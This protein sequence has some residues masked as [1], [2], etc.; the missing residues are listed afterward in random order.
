MDGALCC[1]NMIWKRDGGE[2]HHG[3]HRSRFRAWNSVS[4][5]DKSGHC[6]VLQKEILQVKNPRGFSLSPGSPCGRWS[7]DDKPAD[8]LLARSWW[9]M[10]ITWKFPSLGEPRAHPRLLPT[11]QV[12]PRGQADEGSPGHVPLATAGVKDSLSFSGW[13]SRGSAKE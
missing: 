2:R 4:T 3:A 12:G 8:A 6:A 10:T 11:L 13:G 7:Q 1:R 9:V 5:K